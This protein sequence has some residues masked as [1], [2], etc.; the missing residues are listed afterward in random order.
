MV[1]CSI[2]KSIIFS[3]I[4]QNADTTTVKLVENLVVSYIKGNCLIL[5]ALPMTGL[6]SKLFT[7][8]HTLP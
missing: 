1:H 2:L 6:P 3:G 7:S 5:V 4:I 8:A